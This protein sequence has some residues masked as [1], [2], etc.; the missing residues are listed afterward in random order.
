MSNGIAAATEQI[1][2]G[3]GARLGLDVDMEL[4]EPTAV[5]MR[6]FCEA[7]DWSWTVLERHLALASRP[8]RIVLAH[9]PD[10]QRSA[11]Y[12]LW[13]QRQIHIYPKARNGAD[14]R[15]RDT[16]RY[17]TSTLVHELSH[18][19]D[20]AHDLRLSERFMSMIGGQYR[21]VV[22]RDGQQGYVYAP[23]DNTCGRPLQAA[24]RQDHAE[25]FSESCEAFVVSRCWRSRPHASDTGRAGVGENRLNTIAT[26]FAACRAE[27]PA[28]GR[29]HLSCLLL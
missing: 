8:I 11:Y 6:L 21:R 26:L 7:A 5:A 29:A 22:G 2:H 18:A 3:V 28:P 25:D 13:P 17:L 12:Q 23:A 16:V 19:W 24:A 4:A 27:G 10:G 9:E 20:D 15:F 1:L 14:G